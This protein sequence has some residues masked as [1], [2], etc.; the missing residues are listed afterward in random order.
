M[1]LYLSNRHNLEVEIWQ[2]R[3]HTTLNMTTQH[4]KY[5]VTFKILP[6][7]HNLGVWISAIIVFSIKRTSRIFYA[8]KILWLMNETQWLPKGWVLWQQ[9][10]MSTEKYHKIRSVFERCLSYLSCLMITNI[11][12]SRAAKNV[13]KYTSQFGPSTNRTSRFLSKWVCWKV[14]NKQVSS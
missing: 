14:W 2:G 12:P 3:V 8:S 7:L 11:S 13:I 10:T 6:T 1:T 4:Y 5:I 9:G